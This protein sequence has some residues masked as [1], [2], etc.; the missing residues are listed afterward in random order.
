[1]QAQ[2]AQQNTHLQQYERIG[3]HY[4]IWITERLKKVINQFT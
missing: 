1:M 3:A 4:V 2:I